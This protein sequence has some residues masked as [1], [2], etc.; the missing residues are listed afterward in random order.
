MFTG[1]ITNKGKLRLFKQSKYTFSTD[2]GLILKLKTGGSIAINGVCLT[3]VENSSDT[4]SV[5]IIPETLRK[6]MLGTLK[7]NDEVNLELP[8]TPTSFFEGHIVQGH[9]DGAGTVEDIVSDGNSHLMK[10]KVDP[11]LSGYMI[12]KGS[13]AVNGVA[14]TIIEI[15]DDYFTVGIIPHTY[16]N[17]TFKNLKVGDVVNIEVDMIAKY[18]E[19]F[20]TKS[21]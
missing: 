18:V 15:V 21:Q 11:S 4:F 16:E 20:V 14:L 5:E 19:K 13:V 2:E 1:I 8:M 7:I 17:T 9:V 6:T 10:I 12:K 3:V